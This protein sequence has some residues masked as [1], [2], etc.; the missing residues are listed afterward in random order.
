MRNIWTR[1]KV[2]KAACS[3]AIRCKTILK[4][5]NNI[6]AISLLL[7]TNSDNS[8]RR[9]DPEEFFVIFSVNFEEM[10]LMPILL[11]KN[12]TTQ[13]PS[14]YAQIRSAKIYLDLICTN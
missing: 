7:L 6:T 2:R 14:C 11:D 8:A 1:F 13:A 3:H 4:N 12:A 5:E 10:S 9:S